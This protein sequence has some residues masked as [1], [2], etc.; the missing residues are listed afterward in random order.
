MPVL[1]KPILIS[2]LIALLV[3][4]DESEYEQSRAEALR[5]EAAALQEAQDERARRE[6]WQGL[7]CVAGVGA[8][9]LL[10]VGVAVGSSTRRPNA[11]PK[12]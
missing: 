6:F 9:V 3:G 7:T 8:V 5:R 12:Q 2:I 11:G 10:I 4:C 1:S